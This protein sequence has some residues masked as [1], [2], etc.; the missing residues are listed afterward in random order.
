MTYFIYECSVDS[1]H[2]FAQIEVSIGHDEVRKS[3][4]NWNVVHMHGK[5]V[6]KLRS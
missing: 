3:A 6:D 1:N 4:F 2:S 5:V